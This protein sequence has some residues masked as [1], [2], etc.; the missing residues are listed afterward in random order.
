ISV[1]AGSAPAGACSDAWPRRSVPP[2]GPTGPDVRVTPSPSVSPRPQ[3]GTACDARATAPRPTRTNERLPKDATRRDT[4][5]D[6]DDER[7]FISCFLSHPF[8]HQPP[9]KWEDDGRKIVRG[10][11]NW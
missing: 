3:P 4:E 8:Q 2:S 5:D 6:E 9:P 11:L 1:A 7:A 10:V